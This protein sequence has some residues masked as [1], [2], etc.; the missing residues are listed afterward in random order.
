MLPC[1]AHRGT[2]IAEQNIFLEADD[3]STLSVFSGTKMGRVNPIL[4]CLK[5]FWWFKGAFIMIATPI[6]LAIMLP[7]YEEMGLSQQVLVLLSSIC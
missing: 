3:I 7:F 1:H 5:E 2:Y 6:L 4:G